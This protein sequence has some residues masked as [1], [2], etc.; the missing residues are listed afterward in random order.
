MPV[1]TSKETTNR[2]FS[3]TF[4]CL[5]VV[6][7]VWVFCTL[8][9]STAKPWPG[10]GIGLLMAVIPCPSVSFLCLGWAIMVEQLCCI[11]S[12]WKFLTFWILA[13]ALAKFH[14]PLS[15][16]MLPASSPP[17]QTAVLVDCEPIICITMFGVLVVMV[18]WNVREIVEDMKEFNF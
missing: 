8:P 2:P 15:R 10:D 9:Q 12:F 6:C 5:P 18:W 1:L 11:L 3:E 16:R 4:M 13:V 14:F 7:G 17:F